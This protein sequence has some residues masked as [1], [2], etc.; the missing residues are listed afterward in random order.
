MLNESIKMALEGMVS[1]KL[2]TFLTLLGIIIGVGAVIAMVSLGFGMKENIKNNISKLGS[3]LL[4]ITSG[5]R[6][7]S[8]AR[9]AAGEGA[10]LTF[11][12]GEAILKQVDGVARMSASVNRSYQLVAGN[13]NWTSR[14]EGTTPSNFDIQSLEIEDGRIFRSNDLTS[15][16]R[17]A[18][19]GKTVA[20]SLFPDGEAVGQLMRINKAPFQIIGVLKS[21]GQ[22]GMGQDQ[23]DVVYIP[24]TTAQNRM[25]GITYV[26]RVT[27]QAENENII[28]EVQAEAEQVLRTRHKIKDGDYDNFTVRNMA[29]IMDTMM[30]TANSITMLL[31][32]IAAISLLVGGIGIMNIMLV[33][34]TERTREIGIRKALGATYNNILLQ[35]LIEAMVIGIVGGTLGVVLGVGASFAI[36]Q[37]AG[38][39]TVIS[40]WAIVIA[41]V[42]SVGIG[43]FFGIYPARKAALLDPIDA[44]RYE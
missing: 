21:K 24:L 38:W 44:L 19:I 15:R 36:S 2:R 33:S 32:C 6:T 43:L 27:L 20:D 9:L 39:N 22:S 23:D 14:V 30:E 5:G 4:V 11:E 25:M 13:Q 18:V 35:F 34:V 12:D 10:K 31:G 1:N 41:V 3:N 17:V 16:S 37:F 8:G 7:S 40:V 29:A 42:F 26:Q 28:N